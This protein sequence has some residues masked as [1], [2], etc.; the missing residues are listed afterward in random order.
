MG[1]VLSRLIWCPIVIFFFLISKKG[2]YSK[3]YLMQKGHRTGQRLQKGK[4]NKQRKS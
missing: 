2:V 3:S 4:R 1:D